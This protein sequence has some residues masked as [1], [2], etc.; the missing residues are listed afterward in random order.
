MPTLATLTQ[1]LPT[2]AL[3]IHA[4]APDDSYFAWV[5]S[6]ARSTASRITDLA[7]TVGYDVSPDQET[8]GLVDF[9]LK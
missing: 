1:P 3:S 7:D 2:S 8:C 6:D 4:P 9:Y 5:A